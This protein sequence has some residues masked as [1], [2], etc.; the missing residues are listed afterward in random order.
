VLVSHFLVYVF[1][2][3]KFPLP[4]SH[5]KGLMRPPLMAAASA[6]EFSFCLHSVVCRTAA[7]VRENERETS[8]FLAAVIPPLLFYQLV[9]GGGGGFH[10]GLR[11][12][13]S[14]QH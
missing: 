3:I 13:A 14:M 2:I 6:S 9:V 4:L 11:H 10:T 7:D 5:P 8:L 12:G 1:F